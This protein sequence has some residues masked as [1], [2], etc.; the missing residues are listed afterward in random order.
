MET[1][2][3]QDD[4]RT[5]SALTNLSEVVC[6]EL[7]ASTG[8]NL[9]ATIA[10][11]QEPD[12]F[13]TSPPPRTEPE[14]DSGLHGLADDDE[15]LSSCTTP[16]VAPAPV[17][18]PTPPAASGLFSRLYAFL[19]SIVSILGQLLDHSAPP[20][21]RFSANYESQCPYPHP[22]FIDGSYPDVLLAHRSCSRPILVYLH[23][24]LHQSTQEFCRSVLGAPQII[25]FVNTNFLLWGCTSRTAELFMIAHSLEVSGYPF[26]GVLGEVN[27]RMVVIDRIEGLMP[28]DDVLQKLVQA[29]EMYEA[30]LV[31]L[32]HERLAQTEARNII[33]EQDQA[34]L[35]SLRA[36]Q[37]RER[38]AEEAKR[39]AEQEEQRLAQAAA[40][41]Q[42]AIAAKTLLKEEKRRRIPPP[43]VD[44]GPS[45]AVNVR[46]P[47]GR[48]VQ[49]RFHLQTPLSSVLDY[50][51][52]EADFDMSD[53]QLV[54]NFPRKVC[55]DPAMRLEA[56]DYT[57]FVEPKPA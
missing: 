15:T 17:P 39:I 33:E 27:S 5:L 50:L 46:L 48:R 53:F 47:D 19:A 30:Q 41:E 7:L 23:S 31:A 35:E 44:G 29:H 3:P 12:T 45:T 56:T 54:T 36:D 42:S 10:M 43:P 25:D 13:P 49:R 57:F 32:R 28:A 34:Y 2:Y 21:A 1:Q 20:D 22:A 38:A 6:A 18:P 14:P 9:Q 4:V 55:S 8:G 26:L 40:L 37:A 11:L 24:D 52:A 16:L 51:E